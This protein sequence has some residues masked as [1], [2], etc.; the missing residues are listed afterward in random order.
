[1]LRKHSEAVH[2]AVEQSKAEAPPP[3]AVVPSAKKERG[4]KRKG[5][6]DIAAGILDINQDNKGKLS[7]R[8]SEVFVL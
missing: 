2:N 8:F 1:L 6:K 5:S 4:K 3:P 7:W